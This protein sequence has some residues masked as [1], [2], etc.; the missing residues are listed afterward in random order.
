MSYPVQIIEAA[1]A[2][3][4]DALPSDSRDLYIVSG[5]DGELGIGT[6]SELRGLIA[7]GILPSA[8]MLTFRLEA[9]AA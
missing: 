5:V 3:G 8:E 9:Q 6:P 2:V 4:L 1:P 7:D